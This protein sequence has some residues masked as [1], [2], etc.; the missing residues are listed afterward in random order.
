MEKN[1]KCALTVV[2][3][4]LFGLNVCPA[5]TVKSGMTDE[6][7]VDR[8]MR[9]SKFEDVG[10][11]AYRKCL[12]Q[13]G[14]DTNRLCRIARETYGTNSNKRVRSKVLAL[15]WAFGGAL[16]KR[17]IESCV[18]NPECGEYALRVLR[19]IEGVCSNSVDQ[20]VRFHTLQGNH[21]SDQLQIDKGIAFRDLAEVILRP[22]TDLSLRRYF[23]NAAPSCISNNITYACISDQ[24]LVRIDEAYRNSKR[25]L[26]ILRYA[27]PY[28]TNEQARELLM[29]AIDTLVAY[30][31]ANLP[32]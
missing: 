10:P 28:Q 22:T 11:E 24:S 14:H 18:M 1:V 2:V 23:V 21:V 5:V 13:C 27:L 31:E 12:Q 17:F 19:R 32:E 25:R 30:P 8:I 20:L 9:W 4:V 3:F 29:S 15:F 26:A 7:I 6:D 16:D